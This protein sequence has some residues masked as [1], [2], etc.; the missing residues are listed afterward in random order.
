MECK[1]SGKITAASISKG[2]LSFT[3]AKAIRS[4]SIRSVNSRLPRRSAKFTVKNQVAPGCLNRR[5]SAM[6]FNLTYKLL[7][8]CGSYLTTS[9]R[10]TAERQPQTNYISCSFSFANN[11]SRWWMSSLS[12]ILRTWSF[13][14]VYLICRRSPIFS[15]ETP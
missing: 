8:R 12:K 15:D 9:Y 14:V 7:E 13:T 4:T 1:W 10:T 2:C 5:Y 6:V 11:S 3:W